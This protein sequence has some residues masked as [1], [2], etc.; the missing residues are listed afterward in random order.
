VD[1]VSG[2]NG[3]VD[4]T[5][6]YNSETKFQTLT[7]NRYSAGMED[8]DGNDVAQVTSISELSVP[9]GD[10]ISIA[11]ALHAAPNV[12]MLQK[13]ADS[14]YFR[15]NGAPPNSVNSVAKP[16]LDVRVFPNPTQNN[17]TLA[18]SKSISGPEWQFFVRN[19]LGQLVYSSPKILENQFQ[20]NAGNLENG[21]YFIEIQQ[22][23]QRKVVMFSKID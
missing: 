11:F 5:S 21:V 22:G 7:T 18:V 2:G 6:N 19:T 8:A 23:T 4:I 10:S 1:I 12:Y 17:L 9:A 15:Y 16:T 3:G 20:W 14:A 13:S